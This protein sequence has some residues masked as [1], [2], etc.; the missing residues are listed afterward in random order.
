MEYPS[1]ESFQKSLFHWD[2]AFISPC[3]FNETWCGGVRGKWIP[4]I[5]LI[6]LPDNDNDDN[7][8]QDEKDGY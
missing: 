3:S 6:D 8:T 7:K 2:E 5:K 1:K 4:K